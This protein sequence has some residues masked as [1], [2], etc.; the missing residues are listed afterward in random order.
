MRILLV[1]TTVAALPAMALA[2]PRAFKAPAETPAQAPTQALDQVMGSDDAPVLQV[3]SSAFGANQE[4]PPKYTCDGTQTTP[5]VTWSR[6][7]AG[8][9]SIAILIEDPDAPGGMFTHWLVTGIRPTTTALAAGAAL[10]EGATAARNSKGR[11]GYD[12]PCPPHGRHRYVFRVFA[13]DSAIPPPKDRNGF[14][15][16][17]HGHILAEGRLV[18]TYQ[19]TAPP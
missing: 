7:P 13:L 17:I 16:A 6:V 1:L 11:L 3:T 8:T 18:G 2:A 5:P 4:I 15:S 12:G 14:L 10:P 19:R 9:Q